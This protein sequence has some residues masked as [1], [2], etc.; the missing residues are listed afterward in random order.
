MKL[1]SSPALVWL[2]K[3]H[4]DKPIVAVEFNDAERVAR[5]VRPS[6]IWPK[7]DAAGDRLQALV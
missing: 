3:Q 1:T 7:Q 6:R 5:A 2:G 4:D